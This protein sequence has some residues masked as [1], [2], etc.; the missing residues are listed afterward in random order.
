MA[1][2]TPIEKKKKPPVIHVGNLEARRDFTDVRDMVRGYWLALDG[3]CEPG[4]AYNLCSGKDYSIQ[5]VLDELIRMS[6]AEVE[7]RE[8]PERLRPS[9]VPVLLEVPPERAFGRK[10]E[11]T[12]EYLSRR[13]TAYQTV[14]GWVPSSVKL[15]N[16]ELARAQATLWQV[17][18]SRMPGRHAQRAQQLS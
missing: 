16:E 6:G 7:V 17:V 9:E 15:V 10:G 18:V 11:Y 3:G 8:D 12:V 4:E 2:R 14:L 5:K 1:G 13:W